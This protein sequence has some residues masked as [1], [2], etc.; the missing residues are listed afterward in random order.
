MKE[1]SWKRLTP[2]RKRDMIAQV[3]VNDNSSAATIAERLRDRFQVEPTRNAIVSLYA[4]T[5]DLRTKYPLTGNPGRASGKRSDKSHDP[6]FASIK[7]QK[8]EEMRLRKLETER[9]AKEKAEREKARKDSFEFG[10]Y[11][12]RAI[13][14][15]QWESEYSHNKTLLELEPHDCRWPTNDGSP[16]KFCA[17]EVTSGSKYPYC[18]YHAKLV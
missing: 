15:A 16:F 2:A 5:P 3:Y 6:R 11:K 12:Q 13:K 4:R 7:A 8:A 17:I 9:K 10:G 14:I 18:W 1:H